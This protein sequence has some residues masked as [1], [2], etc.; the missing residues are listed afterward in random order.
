M[1]LLRNAF[2]D[3]G[4]PLS[5]GVY[6]IE[7]F[8]DGSGNRLLVGGD[9]AALVPEHQWGTVSASLPGYVISTQHRV[10]GPAVYR[11]ASGRWNGAPA[12]AVGGDFA[13]AGGKPRG[14]LAI[15]QVSPSGGTCSPAGQPP[16]ITVTSPVG[17]TTSR[18]SP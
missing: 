3:C 8:D 5:G 6:A 12:V 1:R 14:K 10:D 15:W 17:Y 7:G 13:S 9:Y 16:R 4:A 18:W 2:L 11:L